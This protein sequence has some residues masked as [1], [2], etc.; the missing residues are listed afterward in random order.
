MSKQI[1]NIIF[2]PIL[3]SGLY[4]LDLF[5][6]LLNTILQFKN[7]HIIFGTL[8]LLILITS[9]FTTVIYI[10]FRLNKPI[11]FAI[12]YPYKHAGNQIKKIQLIWQGKKN[13]ETFK[14]EDIYAHHITFTEA[15]S[16]SVLQ[17]ALSCLI[18]REFGIS[19][20]YW[21]RSI[22]ISSLVTSLISVCFACA[23]VQIPTLRLTLVG[24][25]IAEQK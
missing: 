5:T 2:G 15:T 18:I 16:E 7:C 9:Y 8:S 23:Q 6:D 24:G 11:N 1:L 21:E 13:P 4:Y 20:N 12:L 25:G 22:T 17:L 19:K 3:A 10:R 14:H